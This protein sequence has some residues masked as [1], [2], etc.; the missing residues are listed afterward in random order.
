VSYPSSAGG[1]AKRQTINDINS[2]FPQVER[3]VALNPSNADT[4]ANMELYVTYIG[5]TDTTIRERGLSLVK[6]H[7]ANPCCA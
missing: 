1:A 6:G 4:L 7:S 3:T 2:Y 5:M